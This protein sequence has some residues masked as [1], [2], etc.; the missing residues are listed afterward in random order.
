MN[1]TSN[2]TRVPVLDLSSYQEQFF[3]EPGEPELV[4]LAGPGYSA[5][6]ILRIADGTRTCRNLSQPNRID[7]YLL[8]LI[9]EGQG[10]YNFGADQY[11]ITADTLCLVSPYT[12]M[13]WN[14]QTDRQKGYGFAFSEEFFHHGLENKHGL[15]DLS[16]FGASD[17]L[18]IRLSP[19]LTAYYISLMDDMAAEA[20][21]GSEFSEDIVRTMLHLLLKKIRA[22]FSTDR[23]LVSPAHPAEVRLTKAFLR[24]C[25]KEFSLL[26]AGKIDKL[27]TLPEL[28]VLLNVTQNHMND[29]V[30]KI[31]GRSAGQHIQQLLVTEAASLL[32]QSV[33]SISEIAYRLGFNDP[34][35][36]SRFYKK[37]TGIS[38]S[39]YR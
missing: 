14:S 19:E 39:A 25:Q 35:Y 7:F 6:E 36:F 30:K 15:Q 21:T 38:P 33:L 27:S 28:S 13:S 10:I 29:T 9:N 23:R 11:Y 20:D 18:V 32:S 26:A 8:V 12:L 37:Q 2:Q 17:H 1:F 24:L 16:L 3:N 31:T 34:S 5:F 22:G 4:S